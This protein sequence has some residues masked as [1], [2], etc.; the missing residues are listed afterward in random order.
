[1]EAGQSCGCAEAAGKRAAA[2]CEIKVTA[3]QRELQQLRAGKFCQSPDAPQ[4][5]LAKLLPMLV[6]PALQA[7]RVGTPAAQAA[8]HQ[9]DLSQRGPFQALNAAFEV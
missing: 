3:L 4:L 6:H 2:S 7:G 9:G 1:M 8:A 5:E